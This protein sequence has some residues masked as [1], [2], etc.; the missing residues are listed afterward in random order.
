MLFARCSKYLSAIS[1]CTLTMPRVALYSARPPSV[2]ASPKG[3]NFRVHTNSLCALLPIGVCFC[4][5]AL[6]VREP[7]HNDYRAEVIMKKGGGNTIDISFS[8]FF[9]CLL[10]SA[11]YKQTLQFYNVCSTSVRPFVCLSICSLKDFSVFFFKFFFDYRYIRI[12]S[13]LKIQSKVKKS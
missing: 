3:S 1:S 7:H 10:S 11:S 5:F 13:L 2:Q 4:H 8:N 6:I 9:R 12:L